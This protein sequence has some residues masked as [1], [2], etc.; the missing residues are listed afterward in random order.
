MSRDSLYADSEPCTSSSRTRKRNCEIA[1]SA[2][3]TACLPSFPMMPTP[4]SAAWIIAT[5]LAPSPTESMR[6]WW[7][8]EGW[9]FFWEG[10]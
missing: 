8:V 1:K 10:E 9:V 7:G 6:L 2:L 5:S 3:L 4:T